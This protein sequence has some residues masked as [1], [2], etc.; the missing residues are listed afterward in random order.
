M[1]NI[2]D[3]VKALFK[4]DGVRK[5]FRV[6]FPNGEFP[7]I[8]NENVVQESVVFTESLCSQDVLKFGTTESSVIEFETVGI[9]NMYGMK[10]EC[11]IEIS[12]SS[13]SAADRSAIA[14]GTWDGTY[15]DNATGKNIF[16]VSQAEVGKNITGQTASRYA[17]VFVPC[18]PSTTYTLSVNNNIFSNGYQAY[19]ETATVTNPNSYTGMATPQ[20]ITTKA[21]TNYLVFQFGISSRAITM[22]DLVDAKI[23]L[24]LGSSVTD[25]EPYGYSDAW[26]RVPYGTFRVESC[27]RDHQAMTHRKVQAYGYTVARISLNSPFE[28]AKLRYET[29]GIKTYTPDLRKLVYAGIGWYNQSALDDY[30]NTDITPWGFPFYDNISNEYV[31][32]T[33]NPYISHYIKATTGKSYTMQF[34]SA[35]GATYPTDALYGIDFGTGLKIDD[36]LA[37]LRPIVESNIPAAKQSEAMRFLKNYLSPHVYWET[38]TFVPELLTY[39]FVGFNSGMP[40]FYPKSADGK[41]M[42]LT[43]TQ[44][45]TLDI[46]GTTLSLNLL[47]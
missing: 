3:S 21:T 25:Y 47:D 4:R 23:Q 5:N 40:V 1:L 37:T 18:N 42:F 19:A 10:I 27:P 32:A 41:S 2:P 17:R 14:A 26:F 6:H 7:D 29:N 43:L 44:S 33:G 36:V 35:E 30:T 13:L 38:T 20:T 12:L 46:D 16:D 11:G 45:V 22:Q 8:T 9:G 31:W 28:L 39:N 24:E 34:S 15:F